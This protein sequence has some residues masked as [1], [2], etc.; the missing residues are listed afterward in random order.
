MAVQ[1]LQ[2][3]CAVSVKP[4]S[5]AWE[6]GVRKCHSLVGVGTTS[7]VAKAEVIEMAGAGRCESCAMV[8][9]EKGSN[10]AFMACF[11][12]LLNVLYN[13]TCTWGEACHCGAGEELV[14]THLPHL[15]SLQHRQILC[16]VPELKPT[17]ELAVA[18]PCT[19]WRV[20]V[21]WHSRGRKI[22]LSAYWCLYCVWENC[23]QLLVVKKKKTQ[24]QTRTL[25]QNHWKTNYL[26]VC[27]CPGEWRWIFVY[28]W[29]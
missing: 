28:L 7:H 14:S 8:A 26:E 19:S 17:Q 5:S 15:C 25:S 29:L 11:Y 2:L 24:C 10:G 20:L 6:R 22:L 21:T 1:P 27:V 9:V 3:T 23:L 12:F 16:Q 18:A 4:A 13:Q